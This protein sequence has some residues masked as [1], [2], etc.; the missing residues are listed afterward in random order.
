MSIGEAEGRFIFF[1]ALLAPRHGGWIWDMGKKAIALG[2][3][4]EEEV[5]ANL[6]S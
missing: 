6:N 1:L 4:K 3:V 5:D 2:E